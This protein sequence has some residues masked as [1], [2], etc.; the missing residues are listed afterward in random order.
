MNIIKK[1]TINKPVEEVWEVLGNQFGQISNWASL[2][3][4]S[5]VYGDSK[6]NGINYSIRETNTLKGITKQEL[7]S[8]EPEKYS[9]SYKS[10]SGTPPMIKEVRA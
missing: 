6:L 8:F 7:T 9:L 3:R 1:I 5:K 2:I 10:I 4:E